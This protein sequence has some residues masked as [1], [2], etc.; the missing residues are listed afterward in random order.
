MTLIRPLPRTAAE[1]ATFAFLDA[2]AKS[3]KSRGKTTVYLPR[4]LKP[5]LQAALMPETVGMTVVVFKDVATSYGQVT[6]K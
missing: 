2:A 4:N 5:L 3:A 1:Y 6:V